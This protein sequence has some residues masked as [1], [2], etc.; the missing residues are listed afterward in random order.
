M[1]T[2][3][4]SRFQR[5]AQSRA[6]ASPASSPSASTITSRTPSRQIERAQAR[7]RKRCPGRMTGRLHGGKAAFRCLRRPSARRPGWA[8]RTTPP[9]HG[10][11]IIFC[12]STGALPAPSRARKVRWIASGVPSTPFVTS[13]TIAGQMPPEGCFNPGWKRR[14]L[15]AGTYEPARAQICCDRRSFGRCGRLPDRQRRLAALQARRR[16]GSSETRSWR[17]RAKRPKASV[18]SSKG[19]VREEWRSRRA[20]RIRHGSARAPCRLCHRADRKAR[21]AIVM[22]RTARH[23][24]APTLR[25]PRALAMVSA[26]MAHLTFSSVRR[27]VVVSGH[28]FRLSTIRRARRRN[29]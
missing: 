11:S 13:A 23:P 21:L 19:R 2:R 28:V 10:P 5:M 29:R 26:V 17:L 20:D 3:R 4:P 9:R 1:R 6:A 25:P 15:E 16:S 24:V 14:S 27:C 12:G 8:R 22:R 7:G 18:S